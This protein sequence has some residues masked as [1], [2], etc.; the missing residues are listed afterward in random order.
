MESTFQKITAKIIRRAKSLKIRIRKKYDSDL[1]LI[2]YLSLSHRYN[3]KFIARS[4]SLKS[5]KSFERNTN[6][7]LKLSSKRIAENP[8]FDTKWY[9]IFDTIMCLLVNRK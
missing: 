2:R 1:W 5:F 4:A 6:R 3:E 8:G 7:L 9:S